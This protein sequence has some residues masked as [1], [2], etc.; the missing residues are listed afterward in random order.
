MLSPLER[1]LAYNPQATAPMKLIRTRWH[2]DILAS[3]A[4]SPIGIDEKLYVW[5]SILGFMI[6]EGSTIGRGDLPLIVRWG[7]KIK[8]VL[9]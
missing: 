5:H 6:M 7:A 1:Q 8:L 2:F 3:I 4:R 9:C